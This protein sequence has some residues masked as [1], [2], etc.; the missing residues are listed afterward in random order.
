MRRFTS[1]SITALFFILVFLFSCK[2]Q[3]DSFTS[4]SLSDYFP[5]Q[6]GKYITYRLDSTV[7]LNFG[8]KMEVHSYQVKYEIDAEVMDNLGRPAYRIYRY[9]R[10][11][12]GTQSWA[13]DNTFFVTP[14]ENQIEYTEDNL[15]FI[16]LHLPIK[17]GFSWKG[18]MYLPDEPYA[19]LFDFQNDN[20]M[21]DWDYY[22]D[23]DP[24]PTETINDQ[25]Y[26]DVLSVKYDEIPDA[27]LTDT[28]PM[29][30]PFIVERSFLNEKYSKNIGLVYKEYTMWDHQPNPTSGGGFDPFT[31]GFS[32]KMWM[33]DHN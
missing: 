13:P 26:N 12:T 15:R 3:T 11:T 8:K 22:Y 18:N 19:T 27:N 10:D 30:E 33:I 28:I 4:E 20:N 16:K 2:K 5:L 31:N 25:T 32:V 24:Q 23:G 17:D 21:Q 7:F 1:I 6:A 14:L 9:I 29:T